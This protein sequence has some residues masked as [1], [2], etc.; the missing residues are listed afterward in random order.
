MQ[1]NLKTGL[2]ENVQTLEHNKRKVFFTSLQKQSVSECTAA[3]SRCL[4][5][6]Y[7]VLGQHTEQEAAAQA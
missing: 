1:N 7:G 2:V 4:L 6:G 5:Q 3:R